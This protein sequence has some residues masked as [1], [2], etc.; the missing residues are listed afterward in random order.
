MLASSA[1]ALSLNH[2]SPSR[3]LQPEYALS[4]MREIVGADL[5]LTASDDNRLSRPA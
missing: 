4:G 2:N 1:P 3:L 5:E